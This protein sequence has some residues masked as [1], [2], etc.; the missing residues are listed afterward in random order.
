MKVVA[1]DAFAMT[2]DIHIDVAGTEGISVS[3]TTTSMD[4]VLTQSDFIT[5]HTP[6]QEDGSA[7]IG[8]QELGKMK[9]FA[10]RKNFLDQALLACFFA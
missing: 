2:K 8:A 4:D 6:A 5:L 9:Y 1:Y 10:S 3:I 7:V